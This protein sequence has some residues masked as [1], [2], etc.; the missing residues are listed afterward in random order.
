MRERRKS[1]LRP[2]HSAAGMRVL[3]EEAG[4]TGASSPEGNNRESSHQ[5]EVYCSATNLTSHRSII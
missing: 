1:K 3:F 5:L 4:S 2:A